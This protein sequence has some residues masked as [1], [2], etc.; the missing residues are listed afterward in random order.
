MKGNWIGVLFFG[1]FAAAGIGIFV[2][3][4]LPMVGQSMS[5]NSWVETPARLES[6]KLAYNRTTDGT[7]YQV[8]AVYSYDYNG[9]RYESS[10]VNWSRGFDNIGSY[11]QDMHAKLTQRARQGGD[12]KVWVDPND[13]AESVID[14]NMRWPILA[15]SGI[16]LLVFGGV[17]LGGLAY[18]VLNWGAGKPYKNNH[19]EKPWLQYPEWN[20]A[21]RVSNSKTGAR[22]MLAFAVFWNLISL[23]GFFVAISAIRNG[24]YEALFALIFPAIGILLLYIWYRMHRS[25]TLTGP[26]PLTLDPFPASLGGQMGGHI[27]MRTL[28]NHAL[29]ESEVTLQSVRQ[30][31]SG[32]NTRQNVLWQRSMVPMW[33]PSDSGL[34]A[35]FCF[36]LI[37]DL[38]TNLDLP[39]SQPPGAMPGISWSLLFSFT[40]KN[41]QKIEREYTDLPVFRTAQSSSIRD[42]EAHY[43]TST[44]S[45][46]A[47]QTRVESVLN[48]VPIAGGHELVYP[49]YRHWAGL[50]MGLF[51]LAFVAI[52]L[53]I[54]DL[55]FKIVFP[56][57]GGLVAIAGLA[58][59]GSGLKVRIGA[60]GITSKRTLF[61]IALKPKFVPSYS[62]EKLTEKASHSTS[63]GNKTVQYYTLVAHGR[64][65]EQ[66]TVAQDLK[67]MGEV[68]AAKRR[69]LE[70]IQF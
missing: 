13:P 1:I 58:W 26:M 4:G 57:V 2:F 47:H 40:L 37:D 19:P 65:G 27:V 20:Q 25:Y 32:K 9:R 38:D 45:Q 49:A 69:L 18:T 7:T 24:E 68:E 54:P 63:T 12:L 21:T 53:A 6:H 22:A 23:F 64:Q 60:E 66:A 52:G 29:A 15:F 62:F 50:F 42:P 36:D 31:R 61:G 41:G 55:I 34:R 14:R 28:S 8:Q 46:A 51:G 48:F 10:R 5:A 17:G 56:I 35:S 70:F 59:F 3:M 39:E 11:H 33:T 43:A 30:Y 67:S 44:A 16:F